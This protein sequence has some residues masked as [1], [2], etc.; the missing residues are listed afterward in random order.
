MTTGVSCGICCHD[1]IPCDKCLVSTI[2]ANGLKLNVLPQL[3]GLSGKR[4]NS[5]DPW[6]TSELCWKI[7]DLSKDKENWQ[8]ED[9]E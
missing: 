9:Y 2:R 8:T 1:S 6:G 5:A 4:N 3:K 7:Q